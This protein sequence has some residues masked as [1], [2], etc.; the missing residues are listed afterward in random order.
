MQATAYA[1]DP[2][3]NPSN[4]IY[5]HDFGEVLTYMAVLNL[6]VSGS[7]ERQNVCLH[8]PTAWLDKP[9]TLNSLMATIKRSAR[10]SIAVPGDVRV[11]LV[12]Y[13]L[14]LSADV[15]HWQ[16]NPTALVDDLEAV[17]PST[18]S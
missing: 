10:H 17:T 9:D 14:I 8:A 16:H 18:S 13:L 2:T 7:S 4:T 11:Q 6:R 1:F 5:G 12:N 3:T 15:M